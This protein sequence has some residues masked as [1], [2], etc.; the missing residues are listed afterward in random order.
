VRTRGG[1]R[2]VTF[3]A[4]LRQPAL[5]PPTAPPPSQPAM[6][7]A[8]ALAYATQPPSSPSPP[9]PSQTL[10]GFAGLGGPLAPVR[11]GGSEASGPVVRALG[12]LEENRNLVQKPRHGDEVAPM[13]EDQC[14]YLDDMRLQTLPVKVEDLDGPQA[15][16][17]LSDRLYALIQVEQGSLAGKITGML[18]QGLDYSEL[19]ALIDDQVALQSKIQ[20]ALEALEAYQ[21]TEVAPMVPTAAQSARVDLKAALKTAHLPAAA[22]Q[23]AAEG[24]AGG[25]V[26][27]QGP[28]G[29]GA[30]SAS[31]A[32]ERGVP[33]RLEAIEISGALTSASVP[34]RGGGCTEEGGRE[35]WGRGEGRAWYGD[36]SSCS[37]S[38]SSSSSECGQECAPSAQNAPPVRQ[39]DSQSE[40]RAARRLEHDGAPAARGGGGGQEQRELA[41]LPTW[42]EKMLGG[43]ASAHARPGYAPV[44]AQAPADGG[45]GGEGGGGGGSGSGGGIG[46]VGEG[47]PPARP[48]KRDVALNILRRVQGEQESHSQTGKRAEGRGG[49]QRG[50]GDAA[51]IKTDKH[52]GGEKDRQKHRK[53]K[54]ESRDLDR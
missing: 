33:V 51:R 34:L 27:I 11:E 1:R 43:E 6:D 5:L 17:M 9:L 12:L 29:G 28:E 35:A 20:E 52:R 42:N 37:R 36:S 49:G 53:A 2:R 46:G 45:G 16:Q 50:G 24:A 3:A 8:A 19:V 32:G 41:S 15:K 13:L 31:G 40:A 23:G 4:G 44:P 48:P 25:R 30:V 7:E 10:S 38:G 14:K 18:L 54:R 39:A 26:A 22:A 47:R 21:Q